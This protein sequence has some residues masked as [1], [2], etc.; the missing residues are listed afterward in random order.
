MGLQANRQFTE[1]TVYF[2]VTFPD[3]SMC[4]PKVESF[5]FVGK[6][7]SDEDTE[8]TWYFQFAGDFARN[9]SI[10]DSS[11]GD[12]RVVLATREDISDMLDLEGVVDALRDAARRLAKRG[13][14]K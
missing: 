4:Y 3:N 1:G 14:Q 2:R 10:I 9:G 6:D 13:K 12:R 11:G 8:E 5:V 7:L